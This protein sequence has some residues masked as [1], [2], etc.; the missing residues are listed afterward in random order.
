MS[1]EVQKPTF[2]EL[3]EQNNIS[4]SH[5]YETC[6]T[7]P[8]EDITVL[9]KYDACFAPKLQRMIAHLNKLAHQSYTAEDIS[10][11]QMYGSLEETKQI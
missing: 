9:Y 4:F 5:F 11:K 6:L 10:I 8:T 3:L 7:V 2:K 1:G